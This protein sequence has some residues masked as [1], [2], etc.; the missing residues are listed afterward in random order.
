MKNSIFKTIQYP[1]GVTELQCEDC[2]SGIPRA[3][4]TRPPIVLA[5]WRSPCA[6]LKRNQQLDTELR[7]AYERYY[8]RVMCDNFGSF[9]S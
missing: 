5:A 9:W 4:N 1:N 6:S 7:R 8:F 3:R 2:P